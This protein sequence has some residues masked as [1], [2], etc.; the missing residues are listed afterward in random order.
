[1]PQTYKAMPSML[2]DH[3]L[4]PFNHKITSFFVNTDGF[5]RYHKMGQ[6]FL[7][8]TQMY[9]HIPG[10]KSLVRKDEILNTLE[11]YTKIFEGKPQCFNRN[12]IFPRSY[13]LHHKEECHAFFELINSQKYKQSLKAEP[14]QYLIKAGFGVHKSQGVFL[15]DDERANSLND[16]YDFGSLCGKKT[17]SFLAQKYITNPLLLDRENKFDFRIYMLIASTNPLIVYYHDG[18]MRV[19]LNRFDKSSKDRATHLTNTYLA[20]QKFA[21]ARKENKTINGMN[22]DELKDYHLWGYEDLLEYLMSTKQVTDK[23]WLDNYLRPSFHKAIIHLVRMGSYTFWNQS[24]VHELHGLDFML[25]E[26]LKLWFIECNPNPLLTGVKPELI[27]PMLRDMFAIQYAYY[28]S[29]MLRLLDVLYHMQQATQNGGDIDYS[30]W[31]AN[32]QAATKNRLEPRYKI[33]ASNS[34]ELIMDENLLPSSDAYFGYIPQECVV[35]TNAF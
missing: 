31:R 23:N 29:R 20:E 12:E 26:D 10:H 1:M 16:E 21:E 7:C 6:H 30:K 11:R 5:Y 24:N 34:W 32:Y 18:Y 3:K 4:F 8:A 17:K 22:A 27:I 28:R 14:V 13:R 25:D 2:Y 35:D 33:Q 15:L 19:S 9:N